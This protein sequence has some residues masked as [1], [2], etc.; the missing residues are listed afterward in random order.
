MAKEGGYTI[1]NVYQGGYST[2]DPNKAYST[3]F[4]G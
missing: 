1:E 2:L 4:T 3:N